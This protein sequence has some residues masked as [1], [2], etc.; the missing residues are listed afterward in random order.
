MTLF[1]SLAD[2]VFPTLSDLDAVRLIGSSFE[3]ELRWLKNATP[4]VESSTSTLLGA[5][6]SDRLTP[7]CA[8]YGIEYTEVNRTLVSV[9]A[10]K[11]LLGGDYQTFTC[12]QSPWTKLTPESFQRL[13]ALLADSCP[14]PEATHALLVA[15]VINDLGKNEDLARLV[16]SITGKTFQNHDDVVYAAAAAH[17]LPSIEAMEPS[18]Q[19][20]L[21]LGLELG[22]RLNI[23]QFAQAECVIASLEGILIMR[24]RSRAFALKFMEVILDVSGAGGHVNTCCATQMTEPV[25][26]TYLTTHRTLLNMIEKRMT[27]K[28]AYDC[29]LLSRKGMLEEAGF[30]KELSINDPADRALL[31]LLTMGRVVETERAIYFVEAFEDLAPETRQSV[32]DALDVDGIDGQASIVFTY[33]PALISEALKNTEG[34]HQALVLGALMRLFARIHENEKAYRHRQQSN[35]RE[36]NLSFAQEAVQSDAFRKDPRFL[37]GLSLPP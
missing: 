18:L 31:R 6:G 3:S 21:L 34:T 25:F 36:V 20:D 7:S 26:Q 22:S 37:D 24:G 12:C 1:A 14:N 10:V 15:I 8:L 32:V 2:G 11:W 30:R 29:L 23:G 28:Q 13:R 19:S 27:P 9:L 16:T 5:L 35:I 33:A 17:L 4:T